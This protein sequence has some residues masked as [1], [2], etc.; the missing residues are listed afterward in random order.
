MPFNKKIFTPVKNI[1][2]SNKIWL[3]SAGLK[4]EYASRYKFGTKVARYF[5]G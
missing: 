4:A 1:Y 3:K 2:S 5:G